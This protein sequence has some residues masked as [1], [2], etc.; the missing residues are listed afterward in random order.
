M[1]KKPRK[2]T[3]KARVLISR[4]SDRRRDPSEPTTDYE[5]SITGFVRRIKQQIS[6][7]KW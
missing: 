4:P 7:V 2:K 1:K 3:Q 5:R 6:G